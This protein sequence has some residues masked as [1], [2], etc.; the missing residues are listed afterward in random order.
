MIH[1]FTRASRHLIFWSLI[2][3]AIGLTGL[4]L[5]LSEIDDYKADLEANISQQ[6]GM[7]VTIGRLG[8]KMRGINPQLVLKDIALNSNS[9]EKPAIEF[10]EI[11]L[12]INLPDMLVNQELLSSTWVTVVGAK[13]TIKRQIDGKLV[14]VGIKSSDGQPQWLLQGQK[15]ELLQSRITWLDESKDAQPMV[16]NQVD[17]AISNDGELHQLNMLMA[18]PENIGDTLRISMELTGNIFEPATVQGRV[19]VD[20]NRI[21]LAGLN[22]VLPSLNPLQIN[23]GTGDVKLW[24]EWQ[25]SQLVSMDISTLVN[26]LAL[27]RQDKQALL[28]QQLKTRMHVEKVDDASHRWQVDV[29]DFSL[30]SSEK[31][32]P[33][34]NFSLAA[35]HLDDVWR[36][37]ALYAGHLDLEE[38]S[39]LTRF[40][41]PLPIDQ[42]E[43]LSQAQLK[44]RLENFTMFADPDSQTIA[45]N[46]QFAHISL[47]PTDSVLGFDNL[48]GWVKGDEQHGAIRFASHEAR[49]IATNL[50][51]TALPINRLQGR[52]VWQQKDTAGLGHVWSL[53]SSSMELDSMHFQSRTRFHIDIPVSEQSV[54]MDLQTAF[55]GE[56]ASEVKHFLPVSIMGEKVVS[57]LDRAFIS[58]KINN[59]GVL[60]YGQLHDFPFT[61]EP[62][63][64]EAVFNGEQFNLSYSPEWPNLTG[65]N[66]EVQFL[67]SGLNVN[68]LQG[69]S[70]K[71]LI[72]HAEVNIP[73]LNKS[74]Q[75]LIQGNAEAGIGQVL[76]F[77]QHTPLRSPVDSLLEAITPQGNTEVTLDLKIPLTDTAPTKVD[78]TAYLKDAKLMVKSL[79]LPVSKIFGELKFNEQGVYSDVIHAS[80]LNHPIQIDINSSDTMTSVNVAGNVDIEDLKAQFDL[81]WWNIAEGA[82]DYKLKLSLPY[83]DTVPKLQVDSMLFG[84]S[85]ALPDSLS[86][87]QQQKEPLSL[88]FSLGD[89][90]L[91]PV[92]LNYANKLKAA[93]QFDTSKKALYSGHVLMGDGEVAQR[94]EAGLKFEINYDRLELQDWLGLVATKDP[95]HY[96]NELKVHTDHALWKTNDLGFLDLALKTQDNHWAGSI[97]SNI[98]KGTFLLPVNNQEDDRIRLDM[99][100]LDLSA[101]KQWGT[102]ESTPLKN[103]SPEQI[104]LLSIVSH[105]TLWRSIDLGLLSLTTERIPEGIGFKHVELTGENQTLVFSG[106]WKYQGEGKSQTD[107]EGHLQIP[108]AGLLL[109]KLDISKDLTETGADADFKVSWNGAPY[110]FSLAGIKGRMDIKLS[111]GR[112][113]SIEPGF[114]RVLGMLALAQWVKRAQLDFGDIYKEGMTFNSIKGHFDIANGIATTQNLLVDA[115]P[116]KIVI[117]GDTNLVNQTIDQLVDVTPKSADAVPIAGTIVGKVMS[118]VGRSLTGKDQEGFFFGS[119]YRVK[120]NWGNAEVIPLHQNDGLL[121]KTW[122]GITD[123]PWIPEQ[124]EK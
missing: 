58:G 30:T 83:D 13:L 9:N 84:V 118:L 60:I 82:T 41:V 23:S 20:G 40:F 123:F 64:F 12:G 29:N 112:I 72:K 45:V 38:A 42:A 117:R 31:Q 88:T 6:I 85:L 93:I 94:Q 37:I 90:Q 1:H 121:K 122:T 48:T 92:L 59:G 18:L 111:N 74:T 65:L 73:I 53:S 16:F 114:G 19:Y 56:D 3:S 57:W 78:G 119:H 21:L 55:S 96:V 107:I 51:R 108:N 28:I 91:L 67:Q 98:A 124:Q 69:Q 89:K 115:V 66:A 43:F 5:I 27:Q 113:L 4:R 97:A 63:V 8:A 95:G 44:G 106:D 24:A 79:A 11:R 10:T 36:N 87:I 46:G 76:S 33:A 81:P 35:Q 71:V 15:Y 54:F 17:L 101:L 32:W 25:H 61:S 77:M 75:L 120:G 2:V 52:L 116:A 80:A 39:M 34:A 109:T 49:L 14:I 26:H 102:K 110:Q 100:L 22:A 99:A 62:G 104:P 70:E 47:A 105:K 50:F 86:K 103:L 7:R 68:I